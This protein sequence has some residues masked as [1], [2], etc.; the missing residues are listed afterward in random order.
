MPLWLQHI[1]YLKLPEESIARSFQEF[2]GQPEDFIFLGLLPSYLERQHSS[3]IYMVDFLMRESARPENGY[4]LYNHS[5]L[6][7]LLKKLQGKKVILFGVSF[8]LLDFLD[9]CESEHAGILSQI[10]TEHW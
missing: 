7:E 6:L 10:S 4:F 9:F 8:A 1:R 3:L 5:E 2:I